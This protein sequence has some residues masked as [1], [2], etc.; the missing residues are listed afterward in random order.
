MICLACLIVLTFLGT[1]YQVDHGLH[2]AKAVYFDSY[3]VL[4]GGIIPFPGTQL[5]LGVLLV[6]LLGY[7][8]QLLIAPTF[9]AGIV[10]IHL[11]LLMMLLGG[12][13][14]HHFAEE[15]NLALQ[16][17]EGSNVSASYTDWE[18]ALIGLADP[19]TGARDIMAAT[20]TGREAG[21]TIE[22]KDASTVVTIDEYYDNCRAFQ[23]R[24]V[25]DAP[26]SQV[27]ITRLEA[28]KRELEPSDNI[29]GGIF[30]VKPGAGEPLRVLLFGEDAA[31]RTIETAEGPYQI[32]LRRKRYPLPVFVSLTDFKRDMHPGTEMAKSY[33]SQVTVEADGVAR[34]VTISMNKPLRHRGYTLYQAS[35]SEQQSGA[36]TSVFAV[37]RNYGRLIPYVSTGIIVAG[38]ILHFLLMLFRRAGSI[39][40][41]V[42]S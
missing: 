21:G 41:G 2:E 28:A 27:G 24:D 32:V 37:T 40:Q 25:K 12:A 23:A 14:T 5:V 17:G 8:S 11:G 1:L 33:S 10:M 13:I 6:N 4:L 31:P 26:L 38:M 30:T 9:K 29:A 36:Q 42:A 3:F 18:L 19:T 15:S 20:L 35:F 39:R 34:D 7:L 22:F 16:E